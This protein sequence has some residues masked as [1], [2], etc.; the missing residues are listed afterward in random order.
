VEVT[1]ILFAERLHVFRC[2][3]SLAFFFALGVTARTVKRAGA[4]SGFDGFP[5]G[6]HSLD[7]GEAKHIFKRLGWRECGF[8]PP[9]QSEGDKIGRAKS[10]PDP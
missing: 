9:G 3:N 2:V 5:D 6:I 1:A 10:E 7:C 4:A 8:H